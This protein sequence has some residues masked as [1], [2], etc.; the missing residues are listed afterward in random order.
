MSEI[1]VDQ[2]ISIRPARAEDAPALFALIDADRAYL[3]RW[4]PWPPDIKSAE[5][6]R[7]HIEKT[8]TPEAASKRLGGLIV[9]QGQLAGSAVIQGVDSTDRSAE[10][11]FWL[12]ERFQH[13]SIMARSCRA[14]LD[15]ALGEKGLNRV[16][17]RAVTGNV[18]SRAVAER[19]GF[20]CEGVQRQATLVQGRYQDLAVYSLLASEWAVLQRRSAPAKDG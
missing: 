6:E 2:E 13:R 7:A 10:I 1:V 15:I 11:G 12:A 18:R 3:S 20:T 19:L 4:L 16:Q 14:L 9:Y 17:L 8:S 5:D